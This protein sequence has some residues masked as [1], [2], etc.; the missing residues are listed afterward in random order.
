MKK[1]YIN[2][3]LSRLT[4]YS[5]L[6]EIIKIYGKHNYKIGTYTDT[7]IFNIHLYHKV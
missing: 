3:P 2:L 4:F 1:V 5:I 6:C 7:R